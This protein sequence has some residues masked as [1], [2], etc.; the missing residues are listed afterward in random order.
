MTPILYSF[1]RCPYAMRARLA[2]SVADVEVELREIVLRDKAPAF[3][4]ASPSGTAPCLDDYGEVTD[5]S[6]DIMTWALRQNDPDGWLNMPEAGYGLIDEADGP[7][8]KALDQT[9]YHT[10]YPDLDPEES[11]ARAMVFLTGL[12]AQLARGFLYG[13]KPTLA[14]MAILPFVRQFAFINKARF[15]A[16]AGP[17][18]TGWL[19]AFLQSDL[20]SSIMP[21]LPKWTEGD[22]P[23]IF[24]GTIAAPGD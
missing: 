19:E 6:L 13:P 17:N 15:D 3:L 9:K 12:E 2:V 18:L 7:F 14:D 4:E 5:E 11:R 10:R 24:K 8:K 21:K 20:F 1:R 23:T 22:A 16:D